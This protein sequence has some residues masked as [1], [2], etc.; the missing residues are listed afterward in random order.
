[1]L[2]AVASVELHFRGKFADTDYLAY[3][4]HS[5]FFKGAKIDFYSEFLHQSY[6]ED[7]QQQINSS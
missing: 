6:F 2:T 4:I 5:C 7:G 3:T 1:M